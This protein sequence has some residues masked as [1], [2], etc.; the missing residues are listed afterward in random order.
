METF[1]E[2]TYEGDLL[3]A[4][5]ISTAYGREPVSKYGESL[6]GI[7]DKTTYTQFNVDV[8]PYIIP[9]DPS[10]G[11]L[12]GI[13]PEPYGNAGAGDR[14]LA[15]FSYRIPLTDREDNRISI[16][17][18]DGYDPAHYE[19]HRRYFRSGGQFYTPKIRIPGNK[20]DLIGSEA[21]LATDLLGMNDD[22]VTGSR[23]IRQQIL[24]QT[25]SFTKGLLYFFATDECLPVCEP[26]QNSRLRYPSSPKMLTAMFLGR[27]STRMV[28]IRVLY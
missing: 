22:W 24:D 12:Y 26:P 13:S 14:H 21:P 16:T 23:E 10:S 19:L 4:A 27:I 28:S 1:V 7:R 11:L 18:P 20:T 8:D 6:A 3:A 17:K 25:T 15:A 2:A 5:G 9:K